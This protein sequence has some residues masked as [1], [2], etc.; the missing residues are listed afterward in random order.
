MFKY[1]WL[2]ATLDKLADIYITLDVSQRD[3][4]A[5]GIELFNQ[6]LATDPLEVG[7]SRVG[8]FRVAFPPLLKVSFHVDVTNRRV[9]VTDVTQ[10]GR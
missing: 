10:Y 8:G 5:A 4:V 6:Q 2:E 9:R 1:L 3:R 7:E